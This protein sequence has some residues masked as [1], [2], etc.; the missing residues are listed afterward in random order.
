MRV[1]ARAR[2][3]DRSAGYRIRF[4]AERQLGEMLVEQKATVGLNQV[5]VP[6]KSGT[7]GEPVLD[8]RQ[9]RHRQEAVISRAEA[10]ASL[11]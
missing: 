7:K 5:A 8:P 6:G 3:P 4:H 10:G 1:S 11:A 9:P 2:A